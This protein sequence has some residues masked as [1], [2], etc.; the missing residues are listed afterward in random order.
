V[1]T[2][3]PIGLSR[4]NGNSMPTPLLVSPLNAG[5]RGRESI[6]Q[7]METDPMTDWSTV[8]CYESSPENVAFK[9]MLE[10]PKAETKLDKRHPSLRA[11]APDRQWILDTYSEC[12]EAVRGQRT[13]IQPKPD[14][15]PSA[16]DR[17]GCRKAADMQLARRARSNGG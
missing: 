11:T 15:L 3:L 6:C 4:L 17:E 13:I 9:L 2:N 14:S 10:I 1:N 5:L 8:R 7:R 12:L 16:T